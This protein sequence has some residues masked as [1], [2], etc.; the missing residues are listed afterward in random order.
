M[1]FQSR[2][3]VVMKKQFQSL[4]SN[5]VYKSGLEVSDKSIPKGLKKERILVE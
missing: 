1:V 4:S 3:F 2:D 5:T